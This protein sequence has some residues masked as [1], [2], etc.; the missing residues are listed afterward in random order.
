[1]RASWPSCLILA[2]HLVSTLTIA[3]TTDAELNDLAALQNLTTLNLW[4]T[5][6]TDAGLRD[7]AALR[8]LTWLNGSRIKVTER[9]L[10]ELQKAL[11]HCEIS[12]FVVSCPPPSNLVP[13]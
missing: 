5:R 13:D 12:N 11:P 7:L 10:A 9:G 3:R 4:S 8:N 6:I 2:H 1:M